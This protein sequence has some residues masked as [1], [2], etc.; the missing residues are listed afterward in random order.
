LEAPSDDGGPLLDAM[1]FDPVGID[2]LSQHT[3]LTADTLSAMLLS[4]E[5]E[6]RVALLPDGRYQRIR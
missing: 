6:N 4:L 3:G 5:L 1:G 2:V